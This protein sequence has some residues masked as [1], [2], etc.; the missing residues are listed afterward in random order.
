MTATHLPNEISPATPAIVWRGATEHQTDLTKH[1]KI[2][3]LHHP[4]TQPINTMKMTHFF[5]MI[6]GLL[7]VSAMARAQ[8]KIGA[9]PG[10]IG[11]SSG[12][13]VEA[14]DGNKT[15][16]NKTTGQVTIQDGT[17]GAGKILTSD[18]TGK[19]SWV[20]PPSGKLIVATLPD[21]QTGFLSIPSNLEKVNLGA[22]ITLTPGNWLIY[23]SFNANNPSSSNQSINLQLYLS[24]SPTGA[25]GAPIPGGVGVGGLPTSITN[26]VAPG[27]LSG[28]ILL[29]GQFSIGFATPQVISVAS[30]TTYYLIGINFS[31]GDTSQPAGLMSI[32]RSVVGTAAFFAQ[33]LDF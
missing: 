10:T 18:A 21:G 8:V 15:I 30:T 19:S 20:R 23:V 13:E 3:P 26:P 12:L 25:G 7:F 2:N 4:A 11:T 9:N 28:Q 33:S 29:P 24:S 17:E 1:P 31:A 5:L 14:T 22:S 6:C 16:V 32:S 27:F